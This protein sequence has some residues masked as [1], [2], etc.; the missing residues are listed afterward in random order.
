MVEMQFFPS[1]T[2]PAAERTFAEVNTETL[3]IFWG[4]VSK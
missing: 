4:L 1:S 3:T 2:G